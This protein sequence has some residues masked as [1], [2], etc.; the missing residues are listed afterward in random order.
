M[1]PVVPSSWQIV[2]L[3]LTAGM[4]TSCAVPAQQT[5]TD[6]PNANPAAVTTKP[7]VIATTTILCDMAKAI[8]NDTIDLTCLL[9][10]GID[11]HVYEPLPDD[12]KAI[13]HAQLI[14]YS[15]Y[16]FEPGLVKLIKSTSNPAPKI[17]IAELAI[18][19]PLFEEQFEEHYLENHHGE[20]KETA[21]NHQTQKR[22]TKTGEP[23]P[24]VWQNAANGARMVG[25][26][27]AQLAKAVPNQAELYAKNAQALQTQLTAIHTWI[28]AQISTIP[29]AQR[30][31]VT[32]HD[33]MGYFAQAYRIPVEGALQGISTDEKPTPKR[34]KELV[35]EVKASGV[36][37]MFAETSVNPKLLEAVA[38]EAHV[39]VASQELYADGLGAAGSDGETY[40]KMLIANTKAIVEGLGGKYSNFQ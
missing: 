14:L 34:V 39:K 29:A 11:G 33:A 12:R 17:A 38:K 16:D 4:V 15:G 26:V 13:D 35:D 2:G 37:T 3:M 21:A 31:L 23:D 5:P 9:K 7:K 1:R 27:Q 19:Q 20:S 25:V 24:H 10:P 8:A 6:R 18:T 36:P 40:P 28:Q 32:T 30:K 22:D